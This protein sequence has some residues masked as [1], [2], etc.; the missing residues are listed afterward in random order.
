MQSNVAQKELKRQS[1]IKEPKRASIN[2]D[3][4]E[5]LKN[6]K[7]AEWVGDVSVKACMRC[8]KKF[9]V[10]NRRHHCRECGGIFCDACSSRKLIINGQL[11]RACENCYESVVSG[12]NKSLGPVTFPSTLSSLDDGSKA[13]FLDNMA[14]SSLTPRPSSL[15]RNLKT[16]EGSSTSRVPQY[17][18][19]KSLLLIRSLGRNNTDKPEIDSCFPQVLPEEML[20]DIIHIAMPNELNKERESLEFNFTFRIDQKKYAKSPPPSEDGDGN[21]DRDSS[22][23]QDSASGSDDSDLLYGFVLYRQKQL[24]VGAEDARTS[25]PICQSLVMI[26]EVP[27]PYLAYRF[28]TNL[29]EALFHILSIASAMQQE[30]ETT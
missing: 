14:E 3:A 15:I 6:N 5:F 30:K 20:D 16:G 2:A 1:K 13:S 28:L 29:E 25:R 11:K 24:Y 21:K 8:E 27:V 4:A 10:T 22:C 26:S 18:W 7:N 17:P 19:V 12:K 9:T 23:S